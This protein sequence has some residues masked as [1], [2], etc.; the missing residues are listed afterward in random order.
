MADIAHHRHGTF[1]VA[2][3][4]EATSKVFLGPTLP[5]AHPE[6][7]VAL[8]VRNTGDAPIAFT[9]KTTQRFEIELVDD[10]GDVV[11]RW[12]TG[13]IF[14]DAV[15]TEQLAPHTSWR[16]QGELPLPNGNS[17]Q[18]LARIFVSADIRPGAQSPLRL[19]FGP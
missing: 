11:A 9:F 17:G 1:Q 5:D 19:Q 4:F 10:A 2:G 8:I 6:L 3:E 18:Y 15:S 13:R 12:S 7:A 14:A 16:F